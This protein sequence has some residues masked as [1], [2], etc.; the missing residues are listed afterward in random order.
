M[1]AGIP[2]YRNFLFERLEKEDKIK[3]LLVIHNGRRY[4]GSGEY[5]NKKLRFIGG[6]KFGFYIGIW[7]YIKKYD[8]IV[9]SYNLRNISCWSFV[10]FRNKWILWGKGL[11][12]N[13]SKIVKFLR[14]I[15][16][17]KAKYI[18]VYNQFKKEEIVKSLSLSDEK[19]IAYNNTI[20]ISNAGI[21]EQLNK[22]YFLYF[23]RIQERKGLLELINEYKKYLDKTKHSFKLRF[24]GD[25]DYKAELIAEV[26]KLELQDYVQFYPGVY[27]DK[28]IKTHFLKAKAYVSPY[29]VGLAVVNSFAYGVPV[30]TCE[31]P[32]V[33]P[34]FH[35]LNKSN[36]SVVKDITDIHHELERF[37][38]IESQLISQEIYEYFE[39]NLDSNYMYEKFITTLSKVNNE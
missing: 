12:D 19:V 24:V 21:E 17:R 7:K 32:Q 35:Y 2:E 8:I 25:G 4:K 1:E 39:Q 20:E 37:S 23:G 9:S 27:G 18:L 26:E 31:K 14:C 38:T 15:T 10:F 28:D 36:S 29:N 16:A 13:E 5:T 6:S 33:G 22:E 11:G 3:D 34:E 30:I